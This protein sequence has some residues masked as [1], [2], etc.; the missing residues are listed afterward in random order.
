MDST[1]WNEAQL[2]AWLRQTL[3]PDGA[4]RLGAMHDAAVL[5]TSLGRPVLCCDRTE[6]GIHF[7]DSA[8]PEQIGW[9]AAA[10][11][12]SDLAATAALPRGILLSLAAPKHR[13]TAWMQAVIQGAIDA[14]DSV[15]AQLI[16]GD[17]TAISRGVSLTVSAHGNLV[18]AAGDLA[19]PGR[20]RA[21]PGQLV[22]VTGPLGGSLLGRHLAIEP[23]ITEGRALWQ[24]GATAMMD[25]SDG[26]AQDAGRIALASNVVIELDSLPL[27]GDAQRLAAETGKSAIQHALFDGEDHELLATITPEGHAALDAILALPLGRVGHATTERPAGVY[28]PAAWLPGEGQPAAANP[29][30][31]S[32]PVWTRLDP[33]DQRGWIHGS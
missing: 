13:T 11:A 20:D 26:L 29:S 23:R 9:K 21:Q 7:D 4:G 22:L 5:E 31:D 19:A 1:G 28:V 6:E 8:R 18:P 3:L 12:L 17:L 27:H 30:Q 33:Y 14:A 2:H 16:G 10:R 32:G 25:V 15:G 24:A